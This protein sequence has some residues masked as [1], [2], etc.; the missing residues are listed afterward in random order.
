M[1]LHPSITSERVVGLVE[2]TF[3]S[4][5]DPGLCVACGEQA[6]NVEPDAREYPCYH[7]G[8]RKVYGAQEL[9]FEVQS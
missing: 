2:S 1:T 8:A 9:L 3:G 7:C 4:L 6:Y 5:E